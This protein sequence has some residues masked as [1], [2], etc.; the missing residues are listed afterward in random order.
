M[1]FYFV[2]TLITV[3]IMYTGSIFFLNDI[4]WLERKKPY[5]LIQY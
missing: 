3:E 2:D 4:K 1:E 5:K